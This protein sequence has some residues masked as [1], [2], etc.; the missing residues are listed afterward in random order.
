MAQVYLK[1]G[2]DLKIFNEDVDKVARSL[3]PVLE[4]DL[5]KNWKNLWVKKQWNFLIAEVENRTEY[6]RIVEDWDA[7]RTYNYH[8]SKWWEVFRRWVWAKMA[9]FTTQEMQEKI[10]DYF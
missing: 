4:W 7:W 9:F 8:S 2:S 3:T 10:K 5:K 1:I 6:A